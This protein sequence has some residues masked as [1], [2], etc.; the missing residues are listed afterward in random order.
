MSFSFVVLSKLRYWILCIQWPQWPLQLRTLVIS[1]IKMIFYYQRVI[2][3]SFTARPLGIGFSVLSYWA[4]V[5]GGFVSK[6]WW[7]KCHFKRLFPEI[8]LGL[9]LIIIIPQ[10]FYIRVSPPEICHSPDHAAIIFSSDF[11]FQNSF[12]SCHSILSLF[13]CCSNSGA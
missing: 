6:S 9:S 3:R 2:E 12:L 8:F 10:S 4:L 5:P 7:S 13:F 11:E 1:A